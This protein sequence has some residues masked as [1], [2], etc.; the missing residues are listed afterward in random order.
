MCGWYVCINR[1]A[2]K[3]D[4][5]WDLCALYVR[6]GVCVSVCVCVH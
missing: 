3:M 1:W 4:G 2:G 5:W 6:A